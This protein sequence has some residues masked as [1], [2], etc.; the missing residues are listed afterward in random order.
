MSKVL[1]VANGPS[2]IEKKLGNRIDSDE[3]D[4]VI[5]FNRWLFN[6]NGEEHKE[7]YS[8]FIGTR[9]DYWVINDLHLTETKLGITKR[10]LYEMVLVV[11]PKFKFF[12]QDTISN[13]EQQYSNIKFLPKEY[14]DSVNNIS[15]FSPKWPSTGI[16]GIHFAL[17][18]FDEVYLHGFDFYDSKYDNLHY[19]EDKNAPHGLNK[20]KFNPSSDH[21]PET[22]KNYINHI[23]KNHNVKFL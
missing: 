5:R 4:K 2:A 12:N 11:I 23:L 3:F 21:T 22:E 10:D 19:F 1:L 18:H 15:D 7:T 16:M 17:N 13:I 20:F 9:C 8:E 6:E 14:E